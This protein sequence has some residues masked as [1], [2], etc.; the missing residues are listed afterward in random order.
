M[1]QT[2]TAVIT[3]AALLLSFPPGL[4]GQQKGRRVYIDRGACEGEACGFGPWKTDKET[5]LYARPDAR[6]RKVGVVRPGPCVEALTGE[7][8]VV[9]GKFL[10]TRPHGPYRPGDV[11]GVY[12]YLGEEVYK[13]RHRGRWR[14]ESL[15]YSPLGTPD[16]K[17]CEAESNCW[18]VFTVRPRSV[19]WARVRDD[20]GLVGWTNKP[21]NFV[22]RYWQ[23]A[24]D[25]PR[26]QGR[27]GEGRRTP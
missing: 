23:S 6:S 19:S 22:N 27:L 5:V 1:P 18:G 4:R 7:V 11:L 2:F 20:F 15:T 13:V 3:L 12:T 17:A 25:C 9:P 8:H 16:L 10:V 26:R 24:G 14:E 21:S